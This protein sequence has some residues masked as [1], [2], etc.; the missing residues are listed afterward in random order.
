M[1]AACGES[2]I[3]QGNGFAV[4]KVQ[5]NQWAL[6]LGNGVLRLRTFTAGG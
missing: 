5:Q 4:P 1:L 3:L 6:A 2:R